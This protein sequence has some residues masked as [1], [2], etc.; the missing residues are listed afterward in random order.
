[1]EPT[2]PAA[3][4][5]P[6]PVLLWMATGAAGLLLI[7]QLVAWL[8]RRHR[9]CHLWAATWGLG[10]GGWSVARWAGLHGQ[11]LGGVSAAVAAALCLA[12]MA[13]G[14]LGVIGNLRRPAMPAKGVLAVMGTGLALALAWAAAPA[15]LG[16][17]VGVRRA[18]GG[19]EIPIVEPGF[20]VG[21][22]ALGLTFL[23]TVAMLRLALRQERP[24]GDV[25]L[26]ASGA[27]VWLASLCN[28][29]LFAMGLWVSTPLHAAGALVLAVVIGA[30]LAVVEVG[31]GAAALP[32]P[33]R[34]G[35]PGGGRPDEPA[36]R[37]PFEDQPTRTH[38]SLD[39]DNEQTVDLDGR[40]DH[41]GPRRDDMMLEALAEAR[42]ASEE[43]QRFLARASHELRTPLH[44]ILGMTELA[45][46]GSLDPTR[47]RYLEAAHR[48][49]QEMLALVEQLLT[50]ART[51]SDRFELAAEP[52][53]LQGFLDDVL[54]LV[55]QQAADKGIELYSVVSPGLP[56][57][58]IGDP[59]RLRQVLVNLVGNAVK[60]TER[61]HV[62]VR[63]SEL[64]AAPGRVGLR[65]A[66]EDTG[67]GIP[68]EEQA[69]VM[70]AFGQ[71]AVGRGRGTG[72]GLAVCAELLRRMG[73]E[74]RLESRVDEGTTFSF[75]VEL[76]LEDPT[77]EITVIDPVLV[78]GE[79]VLIAD[80]HP[81]SAASLRSELA[82]WRLVT[83][84]VGS[85]EEARV[86]LE[87]ARAAGRPYTVLLV[88]AEM[89]GV[90]G[91]A[92]LDLVAGP[93]A[94][95]PGPAVILMLPPDAP[96]GQDAEALRRGARAVI[97]KPL[98]IAD[99]HQ[100]LLQA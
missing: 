10:A 58:V 42:A 35:P 2:L 16:P 24:S 8:R 98:R 14:I 64:P 49:A 63:V 73:S 31:A 94:P 82:A 32:A 22:A 20:V 87:R 34:Q 67:P 47:R 76:E 80:D 19:A 59:Q 60:F 62:A 65:F 66:V 15:P 36:M 38:R 23:V 4:G 70:E 100:A 11:S 6:E 57:T 33:G 52:I 51:E 71:G 46:E 43:R 75:E 55:A 86:E 93:D 90:D 91:W 81:G 37:V 92:L 40:D 78:K 88:D 26:V 12:I 61:G 97:G 28:D 53:G 83:T 85:G 99:L 17:V 30:V 45:L 7:Q 5:T 69:L 48:S 29:L 1:M 72:L 95:E 9:V 27:L 79:R 84:T 68:E 21:I 13:G 44:G 25:A 50:L 96:P 41:G 39:P 77:D 54:D 74:L 89:P 3:A 18:I 56:T